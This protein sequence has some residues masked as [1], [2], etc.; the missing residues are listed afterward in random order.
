[1]DFDI[2]GLEQGLPAIRLRSPDEH[3]LQFVMKS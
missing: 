1:M 2:N 3:K